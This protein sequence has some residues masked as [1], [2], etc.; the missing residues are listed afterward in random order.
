[1]P[2]SRQPTCTISFRIT[3]S[4][5][6]R[7]RQ[8]GAA[9]GLS[10]GEMARELVRERLDESSTLARKLD[11]VGAEIDAFRFDF[12]EAIAMLLRV[13]GAPQTVSREEVD[14]WVDEN[15]RPR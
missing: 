9:A 12:A 13:S 2:K 1:M 15:L 3:R 6:R 4:D 11:R 5:E 14:R 10:A 7:L 8:L